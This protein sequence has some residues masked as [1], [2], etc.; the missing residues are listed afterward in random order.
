MKL[1]GLPDELRPERWPLGILRFQKRAFDNYEDYVA[2]RR[3]V[4]SFAPPSQIRRIV[5]ADQLEKRDSEPMRFQR[6][7][8]GSPGAASS[9][10]GVLRFGRR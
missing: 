7:V 1:P 2:P 10:P 3:Q 9:H 6:N 8:G 5:L 4:Y